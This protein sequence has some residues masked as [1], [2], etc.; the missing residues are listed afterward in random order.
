MGEQFDSMV[1]ER[2]NGSICEEQSA[3]TFP[4]SYSLKVMGKNTSEFYNVV[5]SIV[6][7]HVRP[8]VE[9]SYTTRMSNG[10]RYLAVTATFMMESREQMEALYKSLHGCGHVL[11]TL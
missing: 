2:E 9:I 5:T 4:C 10:D 7:K 11:M 8:G 3:F 6:E 1:E